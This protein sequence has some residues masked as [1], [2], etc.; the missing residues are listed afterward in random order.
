[1]DYWSHRRDEQPHLPRQQE[2]PP[3]PHCRDEQPHLPRQQEPP[4]PPPPSAPPASSPQ[5]HL[6]RQPPPPP[7]PPPPAPAST[8]TSSRREQ[9]HPDPELLLVVQHI[10]A[11]RTDAPL[12]EMLGLT[13]QSEQALKEKY[14]WVILRLHPDKRSQSMASVQQECNHAFLKVQEANQAFRKSQLSGAQGQ[15]PQPGDGAAAAAARPPPPPYDPPP[16]E[17]PPY[18]N[19]QWHFKCDERG[20]WHCSA[21]R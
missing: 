14:R 21:H 20:C 9:A 6:P 4:P 19:R 16:S 15:A 12:W 18:E 13:G 17:P 1:V 5:P 10:N 7:P 11:S 8:A 2:P 3:P